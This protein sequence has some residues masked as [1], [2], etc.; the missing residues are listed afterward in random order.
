MIVV[1]DLHHAY[2]APPAPPALAGVSLTV[3]KGEVVGLVG[4][5]GAGKTTLM[6]AIATLLR[7]PAGRVSVAGYDVLDTRD[8]RRALGYLP[9]RAMLYPQ[10]RAWEYL[11]LFAEIAGHEPAL[12]ARRVTASLEHVGLE[13]RRDQLTREL[14]KGLRQRLAIQATLMHDPEAL[15]LDEPTDGLDPESREQVLSDVRA[16]AA[17][18]KAIML[19]SHLLDEVEQATDRAVILVSGRVVLPVAPSPRRFVLRVRE[20]ASAACELL[21]AHRDV[22]VARVVDDAIELGLTAGARDLADV[23]TALV[24]AGH[25]V[26]EAREERTKL[27]ERFHEATHAKGGGTP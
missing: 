13:A 1:R 5:N 21:S 11:D 25:A 26:V 18:G 4:P 9:E 24:Q 19:S 3:A 15:L 16:L 6:K 7:V 8:V 10:L 17:G 22:A 12:R 2:G 27:K 20:G 14:S 23:V